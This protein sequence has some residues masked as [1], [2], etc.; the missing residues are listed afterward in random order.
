MAVRQ[1]PYRALRD[2][3]TTFCSILLFYLLSILI[4][5]LNGAYTLSHFKP[6]TFTFALVPWDYPNLSN[7]TAATSPFTIVFKQF[8]SSA[9]LT[10]CSQPSSS[11]NPPSLSHRRIF[12]EHRHS[13]F[14]HFRRQSCTFRWHT[15]ALRPRRSVAC[16]TPLRVDDARRCT[17]S[18]AALDQQFQ[19]PMLRQFFH[20]KRAAMGVATESCRR[21]QPGTERRLCC[22]SRVV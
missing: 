15:R 3:L 8:G 20:R 11:Y 13:Q 14:C 6:L 22:C 9:S 19:R 5:G 18:R 1:F 4:I 17:A 2:Q 12:Y 10:L 16:A 21:V 7:K